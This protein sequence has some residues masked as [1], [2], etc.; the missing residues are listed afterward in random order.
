MGLHPD[1]VGVLSYP[2]FA[3]YI[4]FYTNPKEFMDGY[5]NKEDAVD[6][7]N[8][9]HSVQQDLIRRAEAKKEKD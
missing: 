2:D 7:L 1:E 5:F 6:K 4:N 9:F 8:T 3:R